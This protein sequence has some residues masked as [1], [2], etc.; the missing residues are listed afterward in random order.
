[1]IR[2]LT[3]LQSSRMQSFPNPF[4]CKVLEQGLGH[5]ARQNLLDMR[6][7][8]HPLD[9]AKEYLQG[10]TAQS[11]AKDVGI[12]VL[13]RA[14]SV[15]TRGIHS[16]RQIPWEDGE[17][18][19]R[20]IIAR[21]ALLERVLG[22]AEKSALDFVAVKPQ[23][24]PWFQLLHAL[25][26]YGAVTAVRESVAFYDATMGGRE[27]FR[28]LVVDKKKLA[29]LNAEDPLQYENSMRTVKNAQEIDADAATL[30][31]TMMSI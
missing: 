27:E 9:A 5:P 21:D 13:S 20:V 10:L 26:I 29:A 28:E 15:F 18:V 4:I 8:P 11:F 3:P 12:G 14:R 31:Q 23:H 1:M 24:V 22:A 17:A 30:L 16:A 19:V 25:E 2:T 6:T 7:G